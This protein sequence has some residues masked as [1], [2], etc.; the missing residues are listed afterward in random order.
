MCAVNLDVTCC[1]FKIIQIGL[2]T[3]AKNLERIDLCIGLVVIRSPNCQNTFIQTIDLIFI[4]QDDLIDLFAFTL[5]KNNAVMVLVQCEVKVA[6]YACTTSCRHVIEYI[7]YISSGIIRGFDI[8]CERLFLAAKACSDCYALT[9]STRRCDLTG[10]RVDH[11]RIRAFPCNAANVSLE[12]FAVDAL[13]QVQIACD[14]VG[15]RVF[16]KNAFECQRAEYGIAIALTECNIADINI[17]TVF[18]L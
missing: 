17:K 15:I 12:L 3:C 4:F 2:L 10:S 18:R 16:T 11:S 13:N 7:Q 6:L 5:I 14:I 8:Q 9:A 1:C